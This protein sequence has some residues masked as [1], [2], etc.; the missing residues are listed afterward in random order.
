MIE[1]GTDVSSDSTDDRENFL[2]SR[3]AD[4]GLKTSSFNR[5]TCKEAHSHNF[6]V[7]AMELS[8]NSPDRARHSSCWLFWA[9]RYIPNL[10]TTLV[11]RAGGSKI[12]LIWRCISVFVCPVGVSI[13]KQLFQRFDMSSFLFWRNLQFRDG[14]WFAGVAC[15]QPCV[16]RC[17]HKGKFCHWITLTALS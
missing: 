13:C 8:P 12:Y 9:L 15:R 3:L 1:W 17:R 4:A 2:I 11:P 5:S 16:A 7:T 10:L 14:L 6:V